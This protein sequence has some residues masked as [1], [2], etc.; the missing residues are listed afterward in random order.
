MGGDIVGRGG[1]GNFRQVI[2]Y[3]NNNDDNNKNKY[4]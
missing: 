1:R 3:E 4:L 2:I